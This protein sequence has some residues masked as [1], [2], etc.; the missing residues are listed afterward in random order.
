[1]LLVLAALIELTAPDHNGLRYARQAIAP[2]DGSVASR[3]IYLNHNGVTLQPG[4]N[5]ARTNHS[6]VISRAVTIPRWQVDAPT[7]NATVACVRSVFSRFDVT[8]TDVDP[9]AA[10]HM[11]AVFGGAPSALGLDPDIAGISPFTTDCSVIENSIVFAFTDNLPIDT[12]TAC[13]VIAQEIAHSYGL[14]HE[15]L[16][17]DPMTYLEFDGDREFQD[18][19]APCGEHAN[20]DCG[21]QG[22]RCYAQ[23]NSVVLLETRLGKNSGDITPPSLGITS[24]H[25]RATVPPGFQIHA[26]AQDERG[27]ASAQLYVDGR[28]LGEPTLGA[29]PFVFNTPSNL[30]DGQHEFG[31]QVSDGRNLSTETLLLDVRKG[32]PPPEDESSESIFSG[33]ST[34]GAGGLGAGWIVALLAISRARR[35]R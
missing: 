16:P 34:S 9:G 18:Q 23:Q 26:S 6:T 14:D 28:P 19:N 5:D 25:D 30:K 27:I 29:G 2:H 21:I 4:D 10:P 35:R 15:M 7:W 33:C 24:P 20:R 32:A 1:M 31:I 12:R 11:E 8:I 13:E 17:S 3:T 22:N